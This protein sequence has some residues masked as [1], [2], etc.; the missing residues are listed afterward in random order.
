M[1]VA[2]PARRFGGRGAHGTDEKTRVGPAFGEL[3]RRHREGAGLSQ[4][5]LAERA[6]LSADAVSLL[7]PGERR[8]PRRDTVRRLAVALALAPEERAR[9]EAARRGTQ[10]LAALPEHALPA[11]AALPAPLTPLVGRE[12]DEAAAVHLLTH[13]P[14]SGT[15]VRLLTLTGPGGVGKTILAL[16]VAEAVGAGCAEGVVVVALAALRD[17]ALVPAAIAGALG[18]N[19]VAG[20]AITESLTHYLREQ[21]ILLLLDNFEQVAEAAPAVAELLAACPRLR[22]LATGRA[23]L[24]VRGEQ[25]YAVPPLTLPDP[26]YTTDPEA[27]GRPGGGPVRRGPGVV[28]EH[29]QSPVPAVVSGG[30]GGGGRPFR[31]RR[32]AL[33]KA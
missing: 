13:D 12:H 32:A 3:L 6:G 9:F 23:S 11:A 8:Q 25:E 10:D 24:R 18:V 27:L 33:R 26:A 20:Q 17:A 2:R 4:E 21:E 15:P 29:R 16:R 30:T 31:A 1:C 7:E 19:E 28:P 22:V 14:D 5:E